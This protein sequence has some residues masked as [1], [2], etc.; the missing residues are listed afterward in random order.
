EAMEVRLACVVSTLEELKAKLA[1]Y[2]AEAKGIDGL[3]RGT[4]RRDKDGLATDEERQAMI[5]E[6]ATSGRSH[7]LVELWTK[8][9]E[10][11]WRQLCR[12]AAPRRI[13]LPSYPFARER[14]WVPPVRQVPS[15]QAT[16]VGKPLHP[17]LHRN[18]SKPAERQLPEGL[19]K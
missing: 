9:M 8:G 3:Y 19:Y 14:Y 10:V 1:Q 6:C 4:A 7:R 12:E 11:D 15:L 5:E 17:L 13:S 2:L 16:D 18:T